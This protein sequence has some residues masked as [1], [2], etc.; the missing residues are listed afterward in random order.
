MPK[1]PAIAQD[2][3]GRP[4]QPKFWQSFKVQGVDVH[5]THQMSIPKNKQQKNG[6][7]Q[8]PATTATWPKC[9]SMSAPGL[10]TP[11]PKTPS[12]CTHPEQHFP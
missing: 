12:P 3:S 9:A 7:T 11:S 2:K 8:P 10:D 6:L 4:P 1:H 5:S